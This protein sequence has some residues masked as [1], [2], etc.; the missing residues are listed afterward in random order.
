MITK[1]TCEGYVDIIFVYGSYV[2]TT[3]VETEEYSIGFP[4]IATQAE[5]YS[6]LYISSCKI[7]DASQQ[8]PGSVAYDIVFMAKKR[9]CEGSNTLLMLMIKK[10]YFMHCDK[11]RLTTSIRTLKDFVHTFSLKILDRGKSC[12]CLI[13][14]VTPDN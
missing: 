11:I 5:Q 13:N 9:Y 6:A 2:W 8:V 10:E 3:R 1:F 14:Q 12:F 4:T 7:W